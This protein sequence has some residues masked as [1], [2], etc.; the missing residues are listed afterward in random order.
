MFSLYYNNVF[1]IEKKLSN[2]YRRNKKSYLSVKNIQ[3][4]SEV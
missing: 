4:A 2:Y 3:V 1:L